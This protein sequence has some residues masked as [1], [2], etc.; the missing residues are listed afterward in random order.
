MV[1]GGSGRVRQRADNVDENKPPLLIVKKSA[2]R[3]FFGKGHLAHLKTFPSS[4]R[5]A[6]R[7]SKCVPISH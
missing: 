3:P 7:P 1:I 6:R 4:L 2:H 5:S